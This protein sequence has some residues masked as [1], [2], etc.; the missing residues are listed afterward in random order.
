MLK[1]KPINKK[2]K[3]IQFQFSFLCTYIQRAN[4]EKKNYVYQLMNFESGPR[5]TKILTQD[6]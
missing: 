5:K 2:K 6:N 4:S 1:S 3:I